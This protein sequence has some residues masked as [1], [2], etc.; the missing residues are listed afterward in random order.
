LILGSGPIGW[1]WPDG[2]SGAGCQPAVLMIVGIIG[3]IGSG[4]SLVASEL[5]KRGGYLIAGDALGHEAL[6]RPDIKE[7]V[8]K[9]WGRDVLDERGDIQR[10]RLSHK[11]FAN[12]KELRALEALVFPQIGKRIWEEI[13][14]ARLAGS[15]L[16]VLDAA[17]MMEAGWDKN[18]D[19]VIFVDAPC[20]MRL[21]RLLD[22]RGWSAEEVLAR[23][24]AQLP[25]EDKR[26]RA[27][28][29]IDNSEAATRVAE[30]VEK[31]LQE[32]RN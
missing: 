20:A 14:K 30:Q 6:Q 10:R 7:E 31:L 25:L 32:W 18:C 23:E 16:I 15:G 21:Q 27:D 8:I 3:G 19:K 4:K 13:A 9:R 12:T 11:V 24:S 26:R 28:A 5:V 17:V 1:T 29:V 2:Q 22:K